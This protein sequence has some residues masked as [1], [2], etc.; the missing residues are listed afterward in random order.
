MKREFTEI[1]IEFKNE[2]GLIDY[3]NHVYIK[4][5]ENH[6][7]TY[8]GTYVLNIRQWY[9]IIT[10]LSASELAALKIFLEQLDGNST[11]DFW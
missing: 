2:C 9:G 3:A 7:F 10:E 8:I 5:I 1:N 11:V 6:D 4:R